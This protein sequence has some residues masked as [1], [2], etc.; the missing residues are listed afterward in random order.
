MRKKLCLDLALVDIPI[1]NLPAKGELLI[2]DEGVPG[3]S[4]R[5]RASGIRTWIVRSN[6]DGINRRQTLGDA[7]SLPLGH[8]RQLALV[9]DADAGIETGALPK[10]A[11]VADILP[12]FL[13]YGRKGLWKPSTARVMT[14][15]AVRHIRPVFGKKA[16]RDIK[17]ADVVIWHQTVANR[18]SANRMALSTMSGLMRYAEDHGLRPMGSNPCPAS[19]LI[20]SQN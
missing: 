14:Y 4:L 11:T 1:I 16:V 19:S 3:L 7:L 15:I 18:T 6:Q 17:P 8:A 20:F 5:L 9:D 10:H 13:A 2:H 12:R